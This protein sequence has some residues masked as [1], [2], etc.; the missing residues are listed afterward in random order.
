MCVRARGMGEGARVKC[1][2]GMFVCARAREE[3][4][5][6]RAPAGQSRK[7]EETKAATRLRTSRATATCA[8]TLAGKD[9]DTDKWA[10]V[11]K[12]GR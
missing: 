11:G 4:V 3:V 6:E 5:E 10:D 7:E 2:M 8:R 12:D 9:N 1:G